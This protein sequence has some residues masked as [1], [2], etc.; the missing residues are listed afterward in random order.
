MMC[1]A[2]K[3]VG[4]KVKKHGTA[5]CTREIGALALEVG[6]SSQ[7]LLLFHEYIPVQFL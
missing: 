5:L 7:D 1:L 2:A 3:K 6:Q 4:T